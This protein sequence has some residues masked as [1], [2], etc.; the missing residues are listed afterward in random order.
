M[1]SRCVKRCLGGVWRPNNGSAH[2]VVAP[3]DPGDAGEIGCLAPD[4]FHSAS[5]RRARTRAWAFARFSLPTHRRATLRVMTES[6]ADEA[7]ILDSIRETI[8]AD[9]FA[10]V[11]HGGELPIAYTVGLAES[12][13]HSE[14]VV[15][16]LD[17]EVGHDLLDECGEHVREGTT[18]AAGERSAEVLERF[19]IGFRDVHDRALIREALAL[20]T[21]HHGDRDF[22][23]LQVMWP[24][25]DGRFPDDPESTDELRGAQPLM[26]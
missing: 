18:F 8:R 3:L 12:F 13:D 4:S 15:L 5:D 24:D 20:A 7:Q 21:A 10:V 14:L 16:G 26:R 1:R 23:V 6:R 19:Q 11:V 2:L 9:G 17:P 25:E 22:R